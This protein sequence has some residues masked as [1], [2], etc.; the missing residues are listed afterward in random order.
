MSNSRFHLVHH[1]S[2]AGF[3]FVEVLAALVFLGILMPVVISALT[4]SNQAGVLA[5]RSTSALQLAENQLHELLVTQTWN[6]GA[7]RGDFGLAQPGYRW[8]LQRRSWPLD[9]A[10]TELTITVFFQAQGNERQIALTTLA[11]ETELQP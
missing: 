9:E 1:H 10:V 5:N 6:S 8:E 11:S 7:S 4:V 3:T 2:R